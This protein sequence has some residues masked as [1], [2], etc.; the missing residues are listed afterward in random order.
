MHKDDILSMQV[1][2]FAVVA[3]C[4][5]CGYGLIACSRVPEPGS[6]VQDPTP[7]FGHYNSYRT[8]DELK[9]ELPDRS[10]WRVLTD[11]SSAP[12]RDCPRLQEFSFLIDAHDLGE[13]GRLQLTFINGR[14]EATIFT[15]QDFVRYI[16]A[17]ERSGLAFH[18]GQ[19]TIAP[20]TVVW[21]SKQDQRLP[22]VAWRDARFQRQVDAWTRACS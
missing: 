12:R 20:A 16:G 2:R 7:L 6:P 3:A 13:Q 18:G 8:L 4:L 19:A 15:P 22:F 11:S 1:S 17:L 9:S 10:H 14:L 21:Q 5:L